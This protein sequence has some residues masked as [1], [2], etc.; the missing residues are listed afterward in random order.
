M[1]QQHNTR[2]VKGSRGLLKDSCKYKSEVAMNNN[3]EENVVDVSMKEIEIEV[4]G[5]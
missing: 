5:K 4:G 2:E 3:F 1:P